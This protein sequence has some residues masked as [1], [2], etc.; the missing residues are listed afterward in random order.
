[1]NTMVLRLLGRV[2]EEFRRL[3]PGMESQQMALFLAVASSA[4]GG[5]ITMKDLRERLELSNASA[6]RNIA[7]LSKWHRLGRPGL[8]LLEQKEN[9]ADRRY[10]I[11]TLSAKGR[12]LARRITEITG[13]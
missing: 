1:M 12:A 11:I 2:V 9:P 13:G 8:D 5:P 7:A 4:D 6:S 10:K 3:D